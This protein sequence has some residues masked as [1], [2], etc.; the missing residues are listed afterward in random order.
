VRF[1]KLSHY[2]PLEPS[3]ALLSPDTL[4]AYGPDRADAKKTLETSCAFG[5][6]PKSWG[7]RGPYR[8]GPSMT[9]LKSKSPASAAVA[10]GG[11]A[12]DPPMVIRCT[13]LAAS[14]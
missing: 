7:R 5:L 10:R 11:M 9:W 12:L 3:A 2:D 8:S 13:N 14:T 1:V 6:P 4:D